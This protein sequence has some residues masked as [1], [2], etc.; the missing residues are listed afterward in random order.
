VTPQQVWDE[1]RALMESYGQ[2]VTVGSQEE[3]GGSLTVRDVVID[4]AVPDTTSSATLAEMT[5]VDRG[6]GSVAIVLAPEYRV[7][8]RTDSGTGEPLE[9]E[10][11]MTHSGL[12]IIVSG[13]ERAKTYDFS[14][15]GITLTMSGEA[16]AE[17]A[18][19]PIDMRFGIGPNTGQYVVRTGD[20]GRE[21]ESNLEAAAVNIDLTSGSPQGGDAFRLALTLKEVTSTSNG[22]LPADVTLEDLPAALRAG[23]RAA[24]T[25]NYAGSETSFDGS[26]EGTQ[27]AGSGSSQGGAFEF[28]FSPE[29]IVYGGRSQQSQ[30]SFRSSDI[31]LPELSLVFE[32]SDFRLALPVTASDEPRDFALRTALRGL[33]VSDSIWALFDPMGVLPRDPATLA[34]DLAGKARWF[35]DILDPEAAAATTEAPGELNELTLAGLELRLAGAELTG[36][37]AFTFDNADTT[38][39]EG[40]PRPE[41]AVDLTLVGGNALLDKLV[42]MGL[43]P[44]D[45]AMGARMMLGLFA[46]P[47]DG[48]D[49]LVS[50]IEINREGQVLANGQRL[51]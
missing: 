11:L 2:T 49:T 24:G 43:V 28:A 3:S 44:E 38:T 14:A 13:D 41:G 31:P 8:S 32:E 51:R 20:A 30:M 36:S 35:V 23:L 42:S 10:M 12:E 21:F 7:V 17:D 15:D 5:F 22:F 39:F 47:G 25:V 18:S 16:G 4:F 27:S 26:M 29:G 46:R 33:T 50:K 9:M 45:Q 6:D 1:V 37:G 34:L 19:A 48:E 40:M